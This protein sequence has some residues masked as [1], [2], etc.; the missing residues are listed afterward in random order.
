[1]LDFTHT[2]ISFGRSIWSYTKVQKLVAPFIRDRK[3]FMNPKNPGLILDVGSGSNAHPQ[4]INLDY[5]WHPGID[6]CCN[7][8]KGL[9][10]PDGYVAGIFTEH[11]LEH[12][13]FNDAL[14][15]FAEFR[16]IMASGAWLRIVVPNLEI[17]I[18][19]YDAF[20]RTG[21]FSMPYW[22]GD[23]RAD[24]IY[25]PAMSINRIFYDHDH[26][27]IYDFATLNLMLE[28]MDFVE[29]RQMKFGNSR[30]VRLLLDSPNRE[31]ESL[32]VEAQ[33]PR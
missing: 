23:K 2:R 32:Y 11:C 22:E 12:I 17:Y 28:K 18:D 20:R 15:V 7:I 33:K 3:A 19:G 6:I 29:I 31:I 21:E 1:M 13:G 9:P 10:F 5:Q 30:D 26:R 27:F 8:T 16:R 4:N 14:V 24:G 25:S